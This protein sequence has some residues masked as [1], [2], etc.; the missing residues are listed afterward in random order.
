MV[1]L[2]E[3]PASSAGQPLSKCN[4][5]FRRTQAPWHFSNDLCGELQE[6]ALARKARVPLLG[7]TIWYKT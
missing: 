3:T 6:G 1:A 7:A 4:Q 5:Y 2:R